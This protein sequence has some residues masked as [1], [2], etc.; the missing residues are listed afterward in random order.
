[1]VWLLTAAKRIF[2]GIG[3]FFVH[4][5]DSLYLLA[6]DNA[7]VLLNLFSFKRKVGKVT[8][9]GCPGHGGKWPEFIPPKESDSRSCCPALNAMANHGACCLCAM[10][11]G[12]PLIG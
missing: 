1:M 8:L 5:G 2:G 4:V 6:W 9:K 10:T 12:L 3:G 7:L 11:D